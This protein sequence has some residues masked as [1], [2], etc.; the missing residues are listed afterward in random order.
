M[1]ETHVHA[2]EPHI[3]SISTVDEFMTLK[4]QE[5]P[6]LHCS[7]CGSLSPEHAIAAS[8]VEGVRVEMADMKYGW[9]HKLYFAVPHEP[10]HKKVGSSSYMKDGLRVE[11]PIMGTVSVATYKFYTTHLAECSPETLAEWNALVGHRVRLLA[12]KDAADG[13]L[14]WRRW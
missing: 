3:H 13:L 11:D 8:Q 4:N 10:V 7:Y 12:S 2:H 5:H 1:R 6:Y 14:R 9:P